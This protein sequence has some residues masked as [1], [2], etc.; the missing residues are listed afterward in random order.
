MDS[1]RFV[2]LHA[3]PILKTE[4][5]K[6]GTFEYLPVDLLDVKSEK[7]MLLDCFERYTSVPVQWFDVPVTVNTFVTVRRIVLG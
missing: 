7:A 5:R 4:P 3:S 1:H 6:D 2:Y